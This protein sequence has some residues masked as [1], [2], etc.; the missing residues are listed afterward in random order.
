MLNRPGIQGPPI[1]G[2]VRWSPGKVIRDARIEKMESMSWFFVYYE[3]NHVR[4]NSE[5]PTKNRIADK[6]RILKETFYE[7]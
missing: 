5:Y 3:I 6:D 2:Q 4:F 7:T 1:N